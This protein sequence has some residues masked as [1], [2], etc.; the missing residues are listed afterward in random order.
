MESIAPIM[1]ASAGV[2]TLGLAGVY[3]ARVR[4]HGRAQRG[5]ALAA[6]ACLTAGLAVA[7]RSWTWDVAIPI[8]IG[9]VGLGGFVVTAV[10]ARRG[11]DAATR[12]RANSADAATR[13]HVRPLGA[14]VLTGAIV[15]GGLSSTIV[16]LSTAV[17][18]PAEAADRAVLAVTL[19]PCLW[20]GV[21]CCLYAA[22]SRPRA[23]AAVSGLAVLAAFA[24]ASVTLL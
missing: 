20:A 23:Y 19:W 15:G 6:L 3:L 12:A 21:S 2:T 16:A 13:S 4:A 10:A 8:W 11:R 18:L 14:V 9:L 24:A 1:V 17:V 22:P 5:I 7:V